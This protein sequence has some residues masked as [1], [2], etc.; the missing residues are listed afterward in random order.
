MDNAQDFPFKTFVRN[1]DD[2]LDEMLRLEGRGD[3]DNYSACHGCGALD[4]IYRCAHQTCY[5]AG[6]FCS[7]CIVKQHTLLPTHWIETWNGTFFERQSLASLGLVIQ[8]GHPPGFSCPTAT[9]G[10][11]NFALID[12][13]GVHEIR[14]RFCECNSDIPHW[15]QLMR[16]RWWPATV[17]NPQT[18]ATFAVVRLFQIMNC[19]GK[20]SAHDFMRSLELL[21]NNDGLHPVPILRRSF[22]HIIRQYRTTLMMKRAGRG[23]DLSGVNGTKQG[24]LA[25]QCRAC[26]QDGMN[27][28]P[29][30][31]RIDWAQMPE[32]LR[33]VFRLLRILTAMTDHVTDTSIS[34]SLRKT[35]T[36]GSSIGTSH[37]LPRTPSLA[38]A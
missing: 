9:A 3:A 37:R 33:C 4:P 21:T 22:R 1:R 11:K 24:E 18:C 36:F 32:D 34:C 38:M 30:W 31:D 8:L 5:G 27:V 15:R 20:V 10:H 35:A 17:T 26:P 28:P 16:A 2:Y 12:V 19:L 6:L 25:L 23:H 13:T 14:V 29:G 7:A